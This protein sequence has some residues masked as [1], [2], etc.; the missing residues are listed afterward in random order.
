[1]SVCIFGRLKFLHCSDHCLDL[2]QVIDGR[3]YQVGN[4]HH[5]AS[6]G[7]TAQL[8]L[9]RLQQEYYLPDVD[10]V[11]TTGDTCPIP[12]TIR[13]DRQSNDATCTK[14]VRA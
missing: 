3:L 6:R 10:F 2:P 5:F 1:M 11:L 7:R 9:M 12:G 4:A 8:E 14:M 13:F